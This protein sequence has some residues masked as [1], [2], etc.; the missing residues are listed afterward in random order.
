MRDKYLFAVLTNSVLTTI[1]LV[2]T[3]AMLAIALRSVEDSG[4]T[5]EPSTT[6]SSD[7]STPGPTATPTPP[8]QVFVATRYG[9]SYN[10]SPM[11]CVG[12][13][14]YSSQ[15]PTILAAPPAYYHT[16]PCGTVLN[17]CYGDRCQEMVRKDSCPGCAPNHIDLSEA[18]LWYLARC[19]CDILN[20]V[21]VTVLSRPSSSI[22]PAAW[23]SLL[24]E[25]CG[26]SIETREHRVLCVVE[27]LRSIVQP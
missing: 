7:S 24:V 20:N 26:G 15:D 3:V 6:P 22:D 4:Y 8:A 16:W 18:G 12:A 5:V 1:A 10:G 2:A 19:Q 27:V 17:V 14:A 13:G 9:E 23:E 21:T 25:R 11:G